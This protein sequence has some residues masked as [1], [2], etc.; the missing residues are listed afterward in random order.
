[1]GTR[2][3]RPQAEGGIGVK[4]SYMYERSGIYWFQGPKV[5][6]VRPK[7]MSLKTR[8]LDTAIAR[9]SELLCKLPT[10]GS[11]K[12][13]IL[14]F[15]KSR[16]EQGRHTAKSRRNYESV[17]GLFADFVGGQRQLGAIERDDVNRW[18][19]SLVSNCSRAT[20]TAYLT[21]LRA[22]FNWAR[23]EG[24]TS[25]KIFDG[26]VLT[27]PASRASRAG[28][29]Y[30]KEQRDLL[31]AHAEGISVDLQWVMN[32]GFHAGLRYREIIE[33]TPQWFRC[34]GA[35]WRIE[36]EPTDDYGLKWHKSRMIPCNSRLGAFLDDHLNRNH[37]FVVANHAVRGKSEWRWSAQK[38]WRRAHMGAVGPLYSFHAMRHT[39]ASLHVAGGTPIAIVA[40]WLGVNMSVA[41][42]HY[43]KYADGS[44]A[45]DNAL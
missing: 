26:Q 5:N 29:F 7:P 6:G 45:V 31:C 37:R 43:A 36:I 14:G 23:V 39:F 8:D 25:Q 41:F 10:R 42:Q 21:H 44:G 28:E 12:A 19:V 35:S 4:I 20:V 30:T 18:K 40:Q 24:L 1:M 38:Q 27:V 33:A 17:L 3:F 22:F 16:S 15:L 2:V 9:R 11:L 34:S 13:G 32:L